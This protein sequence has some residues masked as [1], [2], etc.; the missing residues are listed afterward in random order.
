M[1]PR[2]IVVGLSGGVDSAVSAWLLK[3][4]G[5]EVV[6]VFMKNWEDDDTDEYC[7][8]RVD[9]VDAASV[10]DVVGIEL[11]EADESPIMPLGAKRSI[12]VYDTVVVGSDGTPTS[13][14]AVDRAAG[15]RG[16]GIDRTPG[17]ILLPAFADRAEILEDEADRIEAAVAE[18]TTDLRRANDEIQRFAYIVSHDLRSPLVNIM[19]FTAE[20]ERADYA[21]SSNV[22]RWASSP[23]W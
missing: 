1:K 3:Q 5:H 13:L 7:T 16:G 20:L 17:E 8:S 12:T 19:G 14:Y 4:Q 21:V 2:R 10:A 18:R 11:D 23:I 9:L 22:A 15:E 6:G